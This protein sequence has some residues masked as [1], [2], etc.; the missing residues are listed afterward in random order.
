MA[1]IEKANGQTVC[2]SSLG[3]ELEDDQC[4]VLAGIM[5]VRT[6]E[7]G[8]TL[9]LEGASDN[10]L[11]LLANGQLAV[12]NAADDEDL[13]AY[14]MR[15]GECAGTRAFIDGTQRRATLRAIGDTTVY[16]LKPE[17]F[18]SL[19]SDHPRVVYKVMRAPLRTAHAN[20]MRMNVQSAE[21]T[22]YI[23]TTKGRY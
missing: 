1:V 17:A 11:F 20:L 9:V 16:T 23:T 12:T 22:Q 5:G 2:E 4:Q 3:V 6:L 18:E 14:V 21:L 10:S 7:D 13:A 15:E 19:L 8:D